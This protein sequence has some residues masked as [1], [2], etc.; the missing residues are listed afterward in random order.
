MPR[1][2]AEHFPLLLAYQVYQHKSLTE[3]SFDE[4]KKSLIKIIKIQTWQTK[5]DAQNNTENI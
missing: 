2:C 5:T 1:G 4:E 3:F